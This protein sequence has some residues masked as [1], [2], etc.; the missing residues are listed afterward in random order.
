MWKAGQRRADD[1]HGG[2]ETINFAADCRMADSALCRANAVGEGV[3][4]GIDLRLDGVEDFAFGERLGFHGRQ[5]LR[6]S[7]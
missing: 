5:S 4:Q 6:Q 7:F 1:F 2:A 3:A